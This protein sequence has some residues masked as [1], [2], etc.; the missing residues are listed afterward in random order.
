VLADVRQCSVKKM[1]KKEFRK[2]EIHVTPASEAQNAMKMAILQYFKLTGC[3]IL[4]GTSA[5]GELERQMQQALDTL[6]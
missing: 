6:D 3:K 2:I 1:F 5:P 4:A